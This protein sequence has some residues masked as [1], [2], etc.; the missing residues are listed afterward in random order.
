MRLHDQTVAV[1]HQRVTH[2]AE[3]RRLA[4]ALVVELRVGIGGALVRFV[5]ALLT[6]NR[7]R[8]CDL[9]WRLYEGTGRQ[10]IAPERLL[11]A[12]LQGPHASSNRTFRP[13]RTGAVPQY[14]SLSATENTSNVRNR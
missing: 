6:G 11:R 5:R 1:F 7:A 9:A 2:E 8:H 3:L 14:V 10:S 12:S 4:V 13:F